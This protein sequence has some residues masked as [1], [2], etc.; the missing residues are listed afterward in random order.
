VDHGKSTLIGRLLHDVGALPAGKVEAIREMC[1]RRGMPFEWAFVTDALQAERDQGI[2]IDASYVRFRAAGRSFVLADAPGHRQFI[3]NMVSGA[4]GADGALVVIDVAEGVGEQSRR[5]AQ[6]LH[7]LGVPK[8]VAAITKMDVVRGDADRFETVAAEFRAAAG[9]LGLEVGAVVPVCARTG[10]NIAERGAA[11]PWYR[12]PTVLE[13]L[14]SFEPAPAPVALPLRVAVQDVYKFVER[15]IIAGRVE[16]G[17]LRVGDTL[18]FSPSNQ[19]ATVRSIESWNATPTEEAV[20]G[21]AVGLTLDEHIFVERG[22]VASHVENP[23]TETN[24]FRGRVF[25]FGRQPL[26]AGR[27]VELRIGAAATAAEIARVERVFDPAGGS[28]EDASA[29]GAGAVADVVLRT[30]SLL[31]IDAAT[32]NPR[33]GRFVL[34]DGGAIAGG[35]LADMRGYPDQRP[36]L[37]RRATNVTRVELRVDADM[38]AAR[39]GHR[40]GVVWLTGLSGAGKSTLAVEAELRLFQMGYQVFVLDGDNLR[41]GLNADLGFAPDDRAE[42]IRRAGEVAALMARAG[43]V[44]ITAF[45]SPYRADRERA[46]RAAGG[47]FHEVHVSAG[48]EVCEGRDPRGLYRMARAGKISDFTGVSAPYEAPESCELVVDTAERSVADSVAD[49]VAYVARAFP[50]AAC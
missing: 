43:L 28:A 44:V 26:A 12:G 38:L 39:N 45:I 20:A 3:S 14:A 36:A 33:T 42:N 27:R 24:V 21:R 11:M 30:R 2:T 46:R 37:T 41:H 15:R 19:V 1:R 47:S 8:V 48:L 9:A 32:A 18:L 34:I 25:W 13:A 7:L 10:D 17:R 29:V 5:H 22:A 50:L 23:P 6:L 35:G 4:A 16:S 31:A 49:L 40:G